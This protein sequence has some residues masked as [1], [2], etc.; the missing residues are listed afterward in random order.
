M[1]PGATAGRSFG[2]RFADWRGTRPGSYRR[3]LQPAVAAGLRSGACRAAEVEL[4]TLSQSSQIVDEAL[5]YARRAR[6]APM[7]VA[8]LDARGCVVALKTEDGS[9]LL[10]PDIA[11]GKAWSALAMG[12]GTRNL[13]GRANSQPSF[14][15]ALASLAEG[16]VLPVPGGVLVRSA[17]GTVLGA[18]GA[19]G[20]VADND[21]AC[22]LAGIRAVGLTADPGTG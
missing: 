21:E 1:A 6:V 15:A 13:A 7:T 10:R 8:V 11:S 9:S 16:R 5:A 14:F 20:D 12:S 17:E 22:A 4:L 19:S 18:V 2:Y 3:P